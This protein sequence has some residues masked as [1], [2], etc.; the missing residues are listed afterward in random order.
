MAIC[1]ALESKRLTTIV[2]L[3]DHQEIDFQFSQRLV[4]LYPEVDFYFVRDREIVDE[5]SNLPCWIPKVFRRK[6]RV[7]KLF[8]I[9]LPRQWV[10]EFL[11][12]KSFDV[13]YI[14]HVSPFLAK[15]FR[16]LCT[17]VVLREDGFSNYVK[18]S[19][20]FFKALVRACCGLTWRYRVW[21]DERWVDSVEVEYPNRLPKSIRHKSSVLNLSA[22]LSII[23]A[24][25]RERL[26]KVF[27]LQD[28]LNFN[29][30]KGCLVLTQPVDKIKL[31]SEDEKL[32][33]YT[34]IV[35][36]FLEHGYRVFLK[37]HPAEEFYKLN[38]NVDYL[39]TNFPIELWPYLTRHRFV[40]CVAL[41]STSIA[42]NSM[43]ISDFNIQ[44]VPLEIFKSE[45]FDQWMGLVDSMEI[46]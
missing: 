6:F 34:R 33:I 8:F 24:E 18:R 19:V 26:S 14:Y 13:G 39:P 31:C 16:G 20:S 42:T 21:G 12:G 7:K 30:P 27:D 36:R 38:R 17:T 32:K 5:F 29:E 25:H 9:E 46:S 40:C 41:C 11:A 28:Y 4:A 35:D 15:V 1:D 2:C 43:S 44:I 10:P 23:D 22:L 3:V 45:R 37:H